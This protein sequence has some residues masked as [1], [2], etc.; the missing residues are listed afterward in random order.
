M[1]QKRDG[2]AAAASVSVIVRCELMRNE[3]VVVLG[4]E[5]ASQVYKSGWITFSVH[6]KPPST[7]PKLMLMRWLR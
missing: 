2:A 1:T 3:S 7:T 6:S 4:P 5:A